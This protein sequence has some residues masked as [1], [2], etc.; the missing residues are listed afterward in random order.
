MAQPNNAVIVNHL[1]F[2]IFIFSHTNCF[3][4]YCRIRLVWNRLDR[5]PAWNGF[6]TI[7]RRNTCLRFNNF[8]LELKI[9][10]ESTLTTFDRRLQIIIFNRFSYRGVMNSLPS[11]F[12]FIC[13]PALACDNCRNR[14]RISFYGA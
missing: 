5:N 13:R 7:T 3:Y 2:S 11:K 1:F 10:L 4:I 14:I 9:Y 8:W 12:L 6:L